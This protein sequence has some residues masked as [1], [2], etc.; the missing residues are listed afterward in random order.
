MKKIIKLSAFVCIASLMGINVLLKPAV[1]VNALTG[2]IIP[3]AANYLRLSEEEAPGV[4]IQNDENTG[5]RQPIIFF[6]TNPSWNIVDIESI[7]YQFRGPEMLQPV[8][9]EVNKDVDYSFVARRDRKWWIGSI[10]QTF[11]VEWNYYE[12]ERD[13]DYFNS[14]G[15]TTVEEMAPWGSSPARKKYRFTIPEMGKTGIVRKLFNL[16]N[17][18]DYR[19]INQ[20]IL[21]QY[22]NSAD[23]YAAYQDLINY[24]S[25][26]FEYYLILPLTTT[27]Q[28]SID[29]LAL[30][31]IDVN[32][33]H[34]TSES[35][36]YENNDGSFGFNV[37]K[38]NNS[39]TT[40]SAF[41]FPGSNQYRLTGVVMTNYSDNDDTKDYS[42]V[43][44]AGNLVH[45]KEIIDTDVL[46]F[47]TTIPIENEKLISYLFNGDNNSILIDIPNEVINCNISIRYEKTDE[48]IEGTMD[49]F[50]MNLLDNNGYYGIAGSLPEETDPN[51]TNWWNKFLGWLSNATGISLPDFQTAF[52]WTGV[53]LIGLLGLVLVSYLIRPLSTVLKALKKKK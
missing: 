11:N 14:T 2:D 22:K 4:W 51:D 46:S 50:G 1:G 49:P 19:D 36:N 28:V 10:V 6:N 35:N 42:V 8:T 47:S 13:S 5:E 18:I 31:A 40:N 26:S 25:S 34:I 38:T 45:Q 17:E 33:N 52:K 27:S 29:Y 23:G 41:F 3:D 37:I 48:F 21:Y 30:N 12:Y 44:Y 20:S 24:Y 43:L 53:A 32:G 16:G 9:G 7:K 15:P 39:L